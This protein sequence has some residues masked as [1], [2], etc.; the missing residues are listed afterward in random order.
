MQHLGGPFQ[1]GHHPEDECQ[2]DVSQEFIVDD[3]FDLFV[4]RLA[5]ISQGLRIGFEFCHIRHS[6]T[7]RHWILFEE[8]CEYRGV[9]HDYSARAGEPSA[10]A[11]AVE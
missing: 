7:D 11:T 5:G 2:Y 1:G 8:T 3:P 4:D 10:T 6:L 9:V